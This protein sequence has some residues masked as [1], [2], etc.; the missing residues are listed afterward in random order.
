M[1]FHRFFQRLAQF[2]F[3]GY[4]VFNRIVVEPITLVILTDFTV[5]APQIA[6]GREL[7][8]G[9]ANWGQCFH[10]RSDVEVTEFVVTH[11]QRDNTDMVAANQVRVLLAV[12]Q[13]EGEHP[14]QIVE[15]FWTFFLIQR[16]DDFAVRTGLELVTVAVFSAQCLMV[17]DFTVDGQS[18]R[19]LF[20][21]QRLGTGVD[22]NNRQAF[23]CENRFITCV[24]PRPVRATVAHQAGE[25][26]RLFTQLDRISFNIQYTENRTHRLLR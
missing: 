16:E 12:V 26:K 14:L 7:L 20:V 3:V 8:N 13:R 19:F 17:V 21:I 6:T 15:E 24:D 11:V 4:V 23:M 10:F 18:V 5:F 25:L 22:V 1:A 2:V 9:A